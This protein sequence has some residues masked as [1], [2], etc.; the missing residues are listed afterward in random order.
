MVMVKPALAYLDV[1]RRVRD[2]VDVPVA[3]YQVS[4]E[5]AMV[6]A[7]AAKGWID[8][9]RIDHGVPARRSAAPAPTSSS[10]TGPPRSRARSGADPNPDAALRDTG[11]GH[12]VRASHLGPFQPRGRRV[13]D[14]A[15]GI[16]VSRKHRTFDLIWVRVGGGMLVMSGSRRAAGPVREPDG[17]SAARA[18]RGAGLALFPGAHPPDGGDTRVLLRPD[19]L[20]R[21]PGAHPAVARV[22]RQATVD[23]DRLG[24]WWA[25]L[26]T[27]TSSCRP[28]G[29]S[30]SSTSRPRRA[31]R[32][33][34]DRGGRAARRPGRR[35]GR[36]AA[37]C[38]SSRRAARPV[39]EDEWWSCHLDTVPED[40]ADTPGMRWHCRDSYVVAPPSVLPFGREVTW[41]ITP[42][43][44]P[45]ARPAAAPG[46]PRGR[47]RGGV[48]S[49]RRAD[50]P[51]VR[52][53]VRGGAAQAARGAWTGGLRPHLE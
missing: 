49:G 33:G 24:G 22:A 30:T 26:P 43:R 41:L 36:R 14:C 52:A 17:A 3:A 35:A 2:A 16:I 21:H 39:D 48:L 19:R 38:S 9:E 47:L 10:P 34:A 29:S 27:P 25:G 51:A 44:S 5:Y 32:A 7:A 31:H 13:P 6:E 18:V 8:R 50:R 37:T 4:G 11:P 53:A 12:P 1:V 23:T 40:V 45:A 42:S 28:A 15:P 20:S 46:G